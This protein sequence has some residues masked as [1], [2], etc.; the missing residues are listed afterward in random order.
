MID[1]TGADERE[2]Q[3]VEPKDISTGEGEPSPSAA[4]GPPTGSSDAVWFYTEAIQE[5]ARKHGIET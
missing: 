2:E 1:P 3:P 4:S 5:I